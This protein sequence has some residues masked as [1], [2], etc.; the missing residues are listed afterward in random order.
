MGEILYVSEKTS[1][2]VMAESKKLSLTLPHLPDVEM[3]A[4]H[5]LEHVAN[6]LG[7][8]ETK[9]HEAAILTNEAIINAI[10]HSDSGTDEILVEYTFSKDKLII[11][12]RDYGKGF[13]KK[14]VDK[15]DIQKKIHAENK[16]GWGL[17]LMESMSDNFIIE[18]D[19]NGTTIT[20]NL[21]LE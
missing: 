10:E 15:P 11:F 4:V 2:P 9:I 3:I 13:E 6:Q 16:R 1:N 20:M 12:V 21:N 8:D 14:N 18:S 5:G 19:E 17:K 7:V